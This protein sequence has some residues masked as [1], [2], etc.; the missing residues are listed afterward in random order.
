M[1]PEE[2]VVAMAAAWGFFGFFGTDLSLLVVDLT[3]VLSKG[4]GHG[5][6]ARHWL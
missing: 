4:C 6:L 3:A 1:A 2:S 5:W